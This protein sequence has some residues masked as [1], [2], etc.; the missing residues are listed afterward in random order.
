MALEVRFMPLK[1][2]ELSAFAQ[3]RHDDGWRLVQLLCVNTDEGIDLQYSFMKGNLIENFTIPS[4]KKGTKVP[5]VTS[6]YLS[7]F[8]F[9][10][11]ANELFGVEIEGNLLD[12]GGN[13]YALSEREPMTV[14]TPEQK[15][16]REKAAK[17][18]KA[19]A[20]KMAREKQGKNDGATGSKEE[21]G[22]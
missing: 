22:E 17:I 3:E 7:A 20:A 19:K 1:L 5:S 11:E 16:A 6:L 9:E 15:A 18:A 8:P 14:I 2:E 4:V 13:F 21:K 12:F 10:N